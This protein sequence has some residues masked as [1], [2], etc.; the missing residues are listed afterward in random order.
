MGDTTT[1]KTSE[2]TPF[3]QQSLR[4]LLWW[5]M[6]IVKTIWRKRPYMK[7]GRPYRYFD[8]HGG[9]GRD[10]DGNPGSPLIFHEVAS[11]HDIP[12]HAMIFEKKEESFESLK[13]YTSNL[14]G[15][16]VYDEDHSLLI[17]EYDKEA[18][19][20]VLDRRKYQFGVVYSDP[21]NANPSFE[22]LH[23][24]TSAYPKIDIILNLAA[25]SYKRTSHLDEYKN[26]KDE[27]LAIKDVWIIR[28]PVDKHQWTMLLGTSWIN[29]PSW[30]EKGF[31][32][33]DTELGREWFDKVAYTKQELH[34]QY[35]PK[36]F[37]DALEVKKK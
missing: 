32:R 1:Y 4:Q 35:N 10:G 24:V 22:V 15:F 3:K 18:S 2:N 36:L 26:L 34:E 16:R 17:S 23:S 31:F 27:L 7:T 29:F 11:E 25:A 12:Y 14:D 13:K 6:D 37:D 5:H 9:E 20:E 33:F 21:S 19:P 30:E 28:K 8:L